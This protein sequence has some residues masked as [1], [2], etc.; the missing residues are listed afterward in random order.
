MDAVAE[1]ELP[2]H[3]VVAA[4]ADPVAPAVEELAHIVVAAVADPAAPA[5]E[6]LHGYAV[7]VPDSTAVEKLSGHLVVAAVA[8]PVA[9]VEELPGHLVVAAVAELFP[10]A[11]SSVCFAAGSFA[12]RVAA[13]GLALGQ[14]VYPFAKPIGSCSHQSWVQFLWL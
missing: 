6:E 3:L 10:T 2:D 14:V 13:A 5:E 8:D 12:E 9:I 11:V 1:Q 7:A 4:V